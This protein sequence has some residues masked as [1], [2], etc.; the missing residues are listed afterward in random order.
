MEALDEI[1][2]E[3]CGT[4]KWWRGQAR[5]GVRT[6][7]NGKVDKFVGKSEFG[8]CFAL[9]AINETRYKHFCSFWYAIQPN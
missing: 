6:C 4:C 2:E 1:M 5:G 8:R 7:K 9:P 3:N